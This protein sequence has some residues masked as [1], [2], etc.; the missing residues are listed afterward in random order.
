[1]LLL[2]ALE[3]FGP[4]SM[5][6]YMPSLPHLA[7]SLHT[8]DTLAQATMSVCMIGL[9]VGQ[10]VAGPLSDRYGRRRPL[11]IGV[12]LFALFS[13]A[14]VFAPNI[15]VLLAVRF[16]QGLAGSAGVVITL[17]IA[18]DLFSGVE[19]SKMLSLL[20]LVSA[21]A[22]ILAPIAGGQLARA[23]DW[24]GIFGVLA[25]IGALLFV[26]AATLLRESHPHGQRTA[27]GFHGT[28]RQFRELARD[29]LFVVLLV[30]SAASGV[31]FFTYLSMSSFVMQNQFGFTPQ[32]F[33]LVFALNALANMG[34]SQVSRA[35]VGR[36]GPLR[37]YLAGY[38]ATVLVVLAM[39]AAALLS[40]PPLVF[41]LCLA[42][43]LAAGSISGPNTTTLAMNGHGE[44][45][46]TAAAMFGMAMFVVGPIVSPLAALGGATAATMALTIAGAVLV[47]G[48][49]AFTIV[50]R[51][52]RH[53]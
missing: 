11:L 28:A 45:A 38:G 12:G 13:L 30:T 7:A 14:C 40:A 53:A 42:A 18:R 20:A 48:A 1:M 9:G 43:Y 29:R 26:L 35:L 33:S 52:A 2:G 15:E 5:D 36:L 46:G 16:L 3:A 32:L 19:L 37:T 24:R 23:M 22:P 25:G 44:R 8:T 6:L 34:G 27:A 47:A 17:A 39:L 50:R 49:L 41:L 10:L 4:L 31:G 51:R 21:S